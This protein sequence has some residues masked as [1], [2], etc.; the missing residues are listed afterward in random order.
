MADKLIATG[1]VLSNY[2]D[3]GMLKAVV[4]MDA[5]ES[6]N[7]RSEGGTGKSIWAKMFKHVVPT[8]TISAKNPRLTEDQHL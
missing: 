3:P 7:G 8:V 4:C 5:V 6:K 1:Y 2:M